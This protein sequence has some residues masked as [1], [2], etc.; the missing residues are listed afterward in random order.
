[1]R[2]FFHSVRLRLA[3]AN[4]AVFGILLIGMMGALVAIRRDAMRRDFEDWLRSG[5][6]EVR[7]RIV[8]W[9]QEPAFGQA[10]GAAPILNL[11]FADLVFQVRTPEGEILFR[12][13]SLGAQPLDSRPGSALED[14]GSGTIQMHTAETVISGADGSAQRIR[15][16]TLVHELEGRGPLL[17]QVGADL[18]RLQN[19]IDAE[20]RLL[21]WLAPLGLLAVA[22]LSWWLVGRAL[23]PL[24]RISRLVSVITVD[25]LDARIA[26][27]PKHH[28][29]QQV[30]DHLNG[31]L[32]R[33]ERGF[34]SLE[35]FLAQASHELKTPIS[36]LLAGSQVLARRER[37]V[38]EYIGFIS[39][40]EAETRRM[41]ETLDSLL[42]LARARAGFPFE[43]QDRVSLVEVVADVASRF[44]EE[45]GRRSL[46]LVTTLDASD[47]GELWVP[48]DE[49]LLRSLVG[50][51]LS[52][53]F[54]ASPA[55]GC[56]SLALE[57]SGESAIVR[58]Q[59]QGPGLS[60]DI[61][62]KLFRPFAAGDARTDRVGLGLSIVK[63]IAELHGG[64]FT[65]TNLSRG[66]ACAE[67]SLPLAR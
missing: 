34:G 14:P 54:K 62:E 67:V 36:V 12:S 20:W 46:N 8:T 40:V 9:M 37:P 53:A 63:G 55:R 47:Q 27:R 4:A 61:R 13:P 66:G 16:A 22:G 26:P 49:E 10:S 59:D 64:S 42:L 5:T 33:L 65:I 30:V 2:Q 56:I 41:G 21:R 11:A 35:A 24:S 28:E 29:L 51:L 60:A 52:N 48:G 39:K 50:N 1:M 7:D 38:D 58:V 6:I 32:E 25:R 43:L 45:A 57:R 17:L 3:V 19:Q 44:Q 18:G 15:V 31:M 23:D